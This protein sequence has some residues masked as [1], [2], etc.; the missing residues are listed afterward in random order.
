MSSILIRRAN[1]VSAGSNPG[2]LPAGYTELAY[3][4]STGTQYIDTGYIPTG[5]NNDIYADVTFLGYKDSTQWAAWFSAYTGENN[6]TYRIVRNGNNTTNVLLYNGAKA[7]GGGVSYTFAA[8]NRYKISLYHDYTYNINGTTGNLNS[9]SGT[10]NTASMKVFGTGKALLR[11][12]SF[13][14]V[15][16]GNTAIDLVP[17]MRDSDNVVGM[18]DLVSNTFLTNAGSGTF[19]YGTL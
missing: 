2:R 1:V 18:Y 15:K 11:F 6:R 9:T 12:H 7:S 4:E 14:L 13:K 17:A 19:N 10:A 3:L 5:T 16:N 8:N